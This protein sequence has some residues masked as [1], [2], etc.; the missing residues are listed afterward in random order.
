[1]KYAFS[2]VF[3]LAMQPLEAYSAISDIYDQAKEKGVKGVILS[4]VVARNIEAADLR[5][6]RELEGRWECNYQEWLRGCVFFA[7]EEREN[8]IN[9]LHYLDDLNI[10]FEHNASTGFELS[11]FRPEKWVFKSI[12]QQL[13]PP[14]ERVWNIADDVAKEKHAG[15]TGGLYLLNYEVDSAC[16]SLLFLYV[17]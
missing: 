6:W 9:A 10:S 7:E 15:E 5:T 8:F 13:C 2:L 11:L 12:Y 4:P 17:F 1:M 16:K 3:L 14:S